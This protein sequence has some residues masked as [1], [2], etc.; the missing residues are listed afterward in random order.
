M[1]APN[2]FGHGV[3]IDY[4]GPPDP[5]TTTSLAST[6][7]RRSNLRITPQSQACAMPAFVDV[8]CR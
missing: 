5:P 8:S 1:P 4:N 3:G 6:R 2:A 7:V